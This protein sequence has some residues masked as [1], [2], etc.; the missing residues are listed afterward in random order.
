LFWIAS[1]L[2]A[3]FLVSALF[4]PGT[5]RISAI[6]AM[7][8]FAAILAIVIQQ[9]G[10]DM[11]LAGTMSVAGVL[12]ST[13]GT[14]PDRLPWALVAAVASAGV[15]G[16]I[17]GM[18]VTR[19]NISPVVATLSTNAIVVGLVRSVSGGSP[20]SVSQTV[21]DISHLSLAGVPMTVLLAL[22]FV[23]LVNAHTRRTIYGRRFVAIGANPS[24]AAA[25][26]CRVFAYQVGTYVVAGGCYAVAGVLFAGFIGS[27]SQTAG[28]DY[29]L[30]AI[31]SVVV[32]GTPFTGGK[33]S[34]VASGLAA[35]FMTQLGQ[36]VLALG[37]G[38][39]TQLLVQAVAIVLAVAM[40]A[41][42][43]KPLVALLGHINA[44][45]AGKRARTQ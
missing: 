8:P 14:T 34:V 38:T 22:A 24:A 11:S 30:P 2:G 15:V 4:A 6:L 33:G 1:A 37:A 13:L 43:P 36:F 42:P 32:G 41:L 21:V 17:N 25:A 12:F 44:A 27:A 20:V 23:V 18:L 45:A 3:L 19:V 7:L 9:R 31:A 39:S 10:L 16:F 35:L 26:G 29:L 40:R 5:V 28:D